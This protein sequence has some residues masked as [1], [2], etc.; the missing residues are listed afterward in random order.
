[1]REPPRDALSAAELAELKGLATELRG[2][3]KRWRRL[4]A[5]LGRA[6]RSAVHALVRD[7][8]LCVLHDCVAP[9]LRDLRS[10]EAE[11]RGLSNQQEV[12]QEP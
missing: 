12:I 8:L 5:R 2:L 11:A 9:A 1:M 4:V 7:R 3:R 10:I 6:R